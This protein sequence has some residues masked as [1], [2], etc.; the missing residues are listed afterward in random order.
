MIQKERTVCPF[1]SL[2]DR[3]KWMCA[4]FDGTFNADK[5]WYGPMLNPGEEGKAAYLKT[6]DGK[7]GCMK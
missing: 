4:K 6:F 2:S 3:R 5:A 7:C 1:T